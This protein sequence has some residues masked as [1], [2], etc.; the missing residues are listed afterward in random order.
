MR[1]P[2]CQSIN[3][4]HQ[5]SGTCTRAPG[6]PDDALSVSRFETQFEV[7]FLAMWMDGLQCCRERR[8][9][10]RKINSL[11]EAVMDQGLTAVL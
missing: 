8:I 11:S 10:G 6:D 2:A 5:S 3:S 1:E 9:S 4:R 7:L